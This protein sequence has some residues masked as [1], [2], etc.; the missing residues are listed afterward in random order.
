[1]PLK[2][3]YC[4][5]D[6]SSKASMA[7]AQ[8]LTP[9]WKLSWAEMPSLL[10]FGQTTLFCPQLLQ[11]ACALVSRP[12]RNVIFPAAL[13]LLCFP[14]AYAVGCCSQMR[15]MCV[16]GKLKH[17]GKKVLKL[18]WQHIDLNWCPCDFKPF[19]EQRTVTWSSNFQ[20]WLKLNLDLLF[21]I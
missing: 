10:G 7:I 17:S 3:P 1:M 21:N 11:L 16:A 15:S 18:S 13:A 9:C 4:C 19:L 8:E 5:N 20:A 14:D 6:R 2:N 12:N